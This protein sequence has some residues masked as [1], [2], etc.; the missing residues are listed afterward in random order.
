MTINPP[1]NAYTVVIHR[2]SNYI[3]NILR[4]EFF[5]SKLFHF[6]R[7]YFYLYFLASLYYVSISFF[8]CRH[9]MKT[10]Y[11]I[12]LGA[13]LWSTTHTGS[14]ACTHTNP[15]PKRDERKKI[16][17]KKKLN[18]IFGLVGMIREGMEGCGG[19][20]WRNKIQEA[21][22]SARELVW[23]MAVKKFIE[24]NISTKEWAR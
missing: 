1:W 21:K 20:N 4:N 18:T 6:G 2:V 13:I 23:E 10:L 3:H 19:V 15:H 12:T 7:A 24:E 16:T 22:Q 5:N 9:M 11:Y 8:Q 17:M 14:H